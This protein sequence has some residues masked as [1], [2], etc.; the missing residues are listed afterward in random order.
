M[1]SL[2]EFRLTVY[3]LYLQLYATQRGCL[4]WKCKTHFNNL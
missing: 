4:T 1:K 2:V 3:C